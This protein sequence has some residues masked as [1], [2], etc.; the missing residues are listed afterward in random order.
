MNKTQEL[1]ELLPVSKLIQYSKEELEEYIT[2][3]KK[4]LGNPLFIKGSLFPGLLH[5]FG[6]WKLVYKTD[7]SNS[8]AD[9]QNLSTVPNGQTRPASG[10]T[11]QIGG[12]ETYEAN[13]KD[14]SSR[15]L[16][17]L[18]R[19]R[20]SCFISNQTEDP[21]YASYTPL[22]LLGQRLYNQVDYSSFETA[23][24][25][26]ILLEP[27]LDEIVQSANKVPLPTAERL[28]EIRDIGLI[29]AGESRH[30]KACFKL[31]GLR[32]TEFEEHK[33]L[34]TMVTQCWLAYP[35]V[36][37]AHTMLLDPYD[38][39]NIPAPLTSDIFVT[40]TKSSKPKTKKPVYTGPW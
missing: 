6:S 18:S 25:I 2:K 29:Q 8:T 31:N 23:T 40:P 15:V 20:R 39:D 17:R 33:A 22:I 11:G 9:D 24:D 36:R 37:V 10:P 5:F 1:I 28:L 34:A 4:L 32:G 3:D 12:K 30:P 14:D 16:Y 13:V 19:V 27:Y 7:S 21:T 38:W 26:Q 35:G